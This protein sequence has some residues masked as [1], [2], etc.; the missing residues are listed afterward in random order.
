MGEP[1]RL[2]TPA[3]QPTTSRI[4]A[5]TAVRAAA[6]MG[7]TT[8]PAATNATAVGRTT[9]AAAPPRPPLVSEGADHHPAGRSRPGV[10]ARSGG[11]GRQATDSTRQHRCSLGGLDDHRCTHDGGSHDGGSHHGRLDN[12]DPT[13]DGAANNDPPAD[14]GPS[15]CTDAPADHIRP[16][17]SNHGRTV[18]LRSAGQPIR[19]QLLRAWRANLQSG[20][21]RLRLLQ[22]HPQLRQR[23]WLHG[24]VPRRHVQHVRRSAG[25]LFLS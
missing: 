20:V 24:G 12:D 4:D 8:G 14:D 11:V 9:S 18:A 17:A 2:G 3:A 1:T 7:T 25:C 19:L 21:R 13:D 5:A 23:D 6:R 16:P 10:P 22:L 15:G